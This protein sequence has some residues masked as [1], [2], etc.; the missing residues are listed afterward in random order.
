[1]AMGCPVVSTR[2]GV[3]ACVE[4]DRHYL[5]LTLRAPCGRGAFPAQRPGAQRPF[6]RQARK[7]VEENMGWPGRAVFRGS[8]FGA[9]DRERMSMLLA[10]IRY[11]YPPRCKSEL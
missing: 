7:Y 8:A 9:P 6:S 3:E 4:R 11:F 1:M 10:A 2:I 5:E